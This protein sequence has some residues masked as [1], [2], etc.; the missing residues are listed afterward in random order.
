MPHGVLKIGGY[1]DCRPDELT[2]RPDMTRHQRKRIR[3]F[4]RGVCQHCNDKPLPGKALCQRH[5]DMSK[6]V[7]RKCYERS[8]EKHL[9]LYGMTRYRLDWIRERRLDVQARLVVG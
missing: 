1:V 8:R 7:S 4:F 3:R 6:E 5:A 2:G 9:K